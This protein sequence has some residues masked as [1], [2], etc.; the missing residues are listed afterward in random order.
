MGESFHVLG[1]DIALNTKDARVIFRLD[2]GN[3]GVEAIDL[4]E[5]EIAADGQGFFGRSRL[6]VVK[7]HMA[8]G[9][10]DDVLSEV[11]GGNAT[12][13]SAPT[14]DCGSFGESSFENFIPTDEATTVLVEV[15][16]HLLDKPRLKFV[17]VFEP[18]FFD[19]LLL[20]GV[21]FPL[22]FGALITADMNELA[23]EDVHDLGE[24]ISA[25]LD[26]FGFGVKDSV[27]DAPPHHD[28]GGFA[29]AEFGICGDGSN[30]MT[31]HIYFRDNG[32]MAFGGVGDD[33]A[34]FVLGVEATV[35]DVVVLGGVPSDDGSWADGADL[36]EARI[37]LD[38]DSPALII[39]QME[40]ECV[41]LEKGESVDEFENFGFGCEMSGD[42]KHDSPPFE[43][44]LIGDGEA[45]NL[46]ALI[47]ES[48]GMY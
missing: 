39:S 43:S 22:G 35:R 11:G 40:V 41:D 7:I 44:G 48:C 30:H 23:G 5:G 28:F 12:T 36:S 1:P 29:V 13:R 14:H 6:V 25:E 9:G 42:I 47:L 10:H 46:P 26:G 45:R 8:C 16:F 2:F 17:F 21:F 20:G 34:E 27:A 15:V 31:G 4:L 24:D 32:D 3:D 37:F 18:P 33:F 38:F 19:S